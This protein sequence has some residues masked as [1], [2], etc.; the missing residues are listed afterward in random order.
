MNI[1]RTLYEKSYEHDACGV[2]FVADIEGKRSNKILQKGLEAVINLTH[3]GAVGG[4]KK[5]GDGAGVLTQLPFELFDEFLSK[6][7]IDQITIGN[8]GVGMYFLPRKE[9][10]THKKSLNLIEKILKEKDIKLIASREVPVND[11][12]LGERAL[13]SKP[14]IFQ[15]FVKD[16]NFTNQNDFERKLYSLRKTIASQSEKNKL[17]EVYCC[18]FSSK[19]IIYKGKIGRAHV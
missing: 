7:D 9:N 16:V 17:D 19:S 6:E 13:E 3:R 12:A 5:T 14:D 4:D 11:F 8:F 10:L 15:F 1:E 2:G 18:S